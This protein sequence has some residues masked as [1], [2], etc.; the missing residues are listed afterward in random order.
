MEPS[1]ESGKKLLKFI[2]D[3]EGSILLHLKF[4]LLD[5]NRSRG[6]RKPQWLRLAS[7]IT[8]ELQDK[9]ELNPGA[10]LEE[11]IEQLRVS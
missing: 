5:D 2:D 6:L 10:A 9:P 7:E 4:E 1:E 11:F 3:P 8:L